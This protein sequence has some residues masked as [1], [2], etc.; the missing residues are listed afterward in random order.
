[1]AATRARVLARAPHLLAASLVLVVALFAFSAATARASITL[2][3][4]TH[5]NTGLG[6]STITVSKPAGVQPGDVLAI[7]LNAG[8]GSIAAPA[9]WTVTWSSVAAYGYAIAA[10]KVA[11]S[12]EP[13]SYTF[14]LGSS[15]RATAGL[16]AW[17]GVEASTA[18]TNT[19]GFGWFF[20]SSSALTPSTTT[21]TANNVILSGVT[22]TGAVTSTIPAGT[23]LLH[24]V[25]TAGGGSGVLTTQV[26][27]SMQA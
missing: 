19:K 2:V 12:S 4:E 23:T 26:A 9:G 22:W 6:A 16:T 10:V 27:Y 25:Q 3:G 1:M 21:T 20:N 11:G 13:S 8:G 17:H 7:G 14:D 5:S 18:G 24:T 15:R